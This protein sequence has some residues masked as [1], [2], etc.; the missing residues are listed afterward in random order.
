MKIQTRLTILALALAA[1][2]CDGKEGTKKEDG[3][4]PAGEAAAASAPEARVNLNTAEESEFKSIPGVGDKMAHE[5]EEYRP[6]ASITQFRKEMGKYVDEATIAGYEKFV[7]VPIAFNDCDAA[8]LQQIPGVDA[9]AAETL[10][11]GRPYDGDVAFLTKVKE[12]GG[13]AA[14]TAA[15]DLIVKDGE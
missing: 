4:A 6:Y 12:V 13:E 2:A 14:E 9:A 1:S 3:S 11:A 5:F 8:T 15:M 10:V 7:F